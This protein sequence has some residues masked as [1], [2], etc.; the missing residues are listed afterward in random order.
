MSVGSIDQVSQAETRVQILT[1]GLYKDN[2]D[3]LVIAPSGLAPLTRL[4]KASLALQS[5]NSFLKGVNKRR[6][7]W[8]GVRS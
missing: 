1:I 7:D 4:S 6:V 2:P 3:R 5:T 8:V